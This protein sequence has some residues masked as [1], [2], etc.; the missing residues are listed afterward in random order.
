MKKFKMKTFQ[1]LVVFF[2]HKNIKCIIPEGVKMFQAK[3]IDILSSDFDWLKR[4]NPDIADYRR[5]VEDSTF[6]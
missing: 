3:V 6:Y 5:C 1:I 2:K 4:L